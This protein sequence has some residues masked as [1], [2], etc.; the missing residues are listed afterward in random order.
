MAQLRNA[1]TLKHGSNV[2]AGNGLEE[3]TQ[4]AET[5]VVASRLT[6][7]GPCVGSFR[8]NAL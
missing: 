4:A 2:G 8:D 1:G 7:S 3:N 5:E 6:S